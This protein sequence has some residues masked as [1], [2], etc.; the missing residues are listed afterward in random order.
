M[1]TYNERGWVLL[2]NGEE[3]VGSDLHQENLKIPYKGH[4]TLLGYVNE[5]IT[6]GLEDPVH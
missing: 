4:K 5:I 1:L 2:R 6:N 3:P